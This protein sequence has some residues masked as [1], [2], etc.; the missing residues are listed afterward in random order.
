MRNK[1]LFILGLLLINSTALFRN[2]SFAFIISKQENRNIY[3]NGWTDANSVKKL[4]LQAQ[5]YGMSY[6]SQFHLFDV[7]SMNIHSSKYLVQTGEVPYIYALDFYYAAGT[8]FSEAYRQK[9]KEAIIE[10]VKK[11]WYE[12]KAIPSFSWH[13]ENPYVDSTFGDYMGC[14]YRY[15]HKEK[16]YPIEHRYVIKEILTQTGGEQ[17][18]FG[19]YK[20]KENQKTRYG[21]PREWF[22]AQCKEIAEIINKFV[23]S[24]G[25]PIPFIFRLWHECEDSWMWWGSSSV[26]IDDYKKFFIL[27]EKCIKQYAPKA[28]I[29]W[30]YCTDRN[31]KT[32]KEFM[33]RYPGDKYVDIIGYDDYQIGCSNKE[34]EAIEKARIVTQ[35]AKEHGKVAGLFETAN[36]QD[37]SKDN[38]MSDYL[39]PLLETKGVNLGFVQMWIGGAFDTRQQ[40]NDRKKF[41]KSSNILMI[42]SNE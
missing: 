2:R 13:L 14:R 6:F 7:R 22:D 9:N 36:L 32:K 3:W 30:A 8:Y 1:V 17:C 21:N 4:L 25:K 24:K 31:W 29:L 16:T 18:G 39:L 34:N 19:M 20:A 38:F 27:T 33:A 40:Y 10:V 5:I 37:E 23:D 28:Q 42:K 41:L 12:N 11:Q 35:T 26:S 15:G